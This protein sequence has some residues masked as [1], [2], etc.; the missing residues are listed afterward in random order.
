MSNV[1]HGRI[2]SI[3]LA[4]MVLAG[5]LPAAKP[6]PQ[7]IPLAG[8][9]PVAITPKSAPIRLS[10]A[11][12]CTVYMGDNPIYYI[13]PWVYG[14][15]LYKSYQ[16]PSLTCDKPYPFTVDAVHIPLVYLDSGIIYLSADVETADL[17]NPSCP[18]PGAMLTIS[19]T[20]EVTLGNNFYL[21]SIP[22]DSPV[23]VN[24]PYFVGIYIAAD[25]NPSAAAVV[26]D[27]LPVRCVGYNDW[28][29]GYVDLDTVH[30][31]NTGEKIFPG[32]FIQFSSG[33]TGGGGGGG[34]EPA[35]AARMINP[36]EGQFLGNTVDLWA[37]DAAGSKIIKRARFQ[38]YRTGSW[39]DIGADTTVSQ[40]LRN[41]VNPSGSGDGLSYTWN[42]SGLPEGDYQIRAIITDTLGRADTAQVTS[43][44]D[45]TPPFPAFLLPTFAQN[46]CGGISAKI[47][48]TDEDISYV[49]FDMKKA[50]RDLVLPVPVIDQRLGGDVNG[51]PGDGNLVANGEYGEY[52]S[53][54][55]AAAMAIKYWYS[56]GYS[57]LLK[58]N[59]TF[60]S[61]IQL[62]SRL[63]AAMM[64]RENSGAFDGE[65]VGGL[66]DYCTAHG[67]E[68]EL[69]TDRRP[70]LALLRSWIED[71]EYA[72]M[73]GLSGA[74]GFWMTMAGASGLADS[75]GQYTLR[76]INPITAFTEMHKMK[77]DA[78][79]LLL[80]YGGQWLEVDLMVGLVPLS[81]TVSRT[82]VGYDASAA[83][84]WGFYWST[85]T[86]AE[87]SLYF[88]EATVNDLG[89]HKGIVSALVQNDCRIDFIAGDVNNDGQVNVA[90]MVYLI[91]FL[92]QNGPPPAAGNAV[93]DINC[94]G[95]V[96]LADV[97]YLYKYLFFAGPAPCRR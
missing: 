81:F 33:I 74:P 36:T 40:P 7:V 11:D 58:E 32:R 24:G 75:A 21:L 83:D 67:G 71:Y 89:G 12:T 19:S 6:T 65:F 73:I 18:K 41:G 92:Y 77:E 28:G 93:C 91:A 17:T 53:G 55:A 69:K 68:F 27:S 44:V 49:S 90:D 10:A 30:N 29:E 97:I 87:D 60:L 95:A 80:Q 96:N 42:S 76:T 57:N 38:Y 35:P 70:T 61:D 34:T 85:E 2:A 45:P 94:D 62:M 78:G 14:D 86:L 66:R 51:V 72:V 54:P 15:E 63:G 13:Y 82:P 84:G 23:V 39:F 9:T 79:Q 47:S 1:P 5:T 22:L 4:I 8:R 37:D 16:D 59:T 43:H 26:T 88:L 56:K 3:L 31:V 25:G 50:S 48:C 64:V 20:Y 52:C 46:V